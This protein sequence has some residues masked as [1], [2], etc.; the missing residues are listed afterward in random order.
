MNIKIVGNN[1]NIGEALREHV[2][3][4]LEARIKKHFDGS[5][6]SQ[7]SVSKNH[8]GFSVNITV[9]LNKKR[10]NTINS[11][12]KSHDPYL[13]V[14]FAAEKMFRQIIKHKERITHHHGLSSI[15]EKESEIVENYDEYLVNEKDEDDITKENPEIVKKGNLNVEEM[16]ISD[17]VMKMNLESLNFLIFINK[18]NFKVSIL[19]KGKN[20]KII[21]VKLLKKETRS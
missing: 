9:K 8:E 15:S 11:T 10:F 13:A 1:F 4:S 16:S 5:F 2:L 14:G 3:S 19:Y 7:V 12:A 20:D 18:E 21:L 6:E 17:A